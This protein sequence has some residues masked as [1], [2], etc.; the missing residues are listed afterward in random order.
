M[1]IGRKVKKLMD[2]K[3][4]T[5]QEFADI[6]GISPTQINKLVNDI[7]NPSINT[8]ERVA[9]AFGKQIVIEFI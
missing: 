2:E 1:T 8:L 5:Q 7:G 9:K 3:G 6:S 4:W